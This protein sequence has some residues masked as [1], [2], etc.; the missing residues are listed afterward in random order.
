M[1]LFL[2]L[3]FLISPLFNLF[4]QEASTIKDTLILFYDTGDY[5]ISAK[6][7]NQIKDYFNGKNQSK[8]KV[9][10]YADY[11][12]STSSNDELA[13]KRAKHL[14]EFLL[15]RELA[16]TTTVISKGEMPKPANFSETEGNPNDRKT[17]CFI[18]YS[19]NTK[20]LE[21]V[22]TKDDLLKK[23]LSY[24][25]TLPTLKVG[26]RI[27]LKNIL[28]YLGKA[29]IIPNSFS[30][31]Q[32]LKET[33]VINPNLSIELRGHVCCGV[34]TEEFE[35]VPTPK[36]S[37]YNMQLSL[38]RTLAVKNYLID[39]GIDTQRVSVKGMGFLEPLYYPEENEMHRQLNRRI[40]LVIV[41][42]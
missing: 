8:I 12:G 31:L 29:V 42:K 27:I 13:L 7:Q 20:E 19:L 40:E 35:G 33:L 25:D 22:I 34:I 30:E 15:D 4:S 3:L 6:Q 23:Q 1:R 21:G 5:L 41:K 11:V 37:D 16:D 17:V 32:A 2:T 28:F 9:V 26:E 10:G 18:T 39:N 24:L 38:N 14:Q 36:Q